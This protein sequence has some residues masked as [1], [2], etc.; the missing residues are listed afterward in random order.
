MFFTILP[1][2]LGGLDVQLMQKVKIKVPVSIAEQ[3][4]ACT[5]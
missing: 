1:A 2:S 4:K 3:S 5:V